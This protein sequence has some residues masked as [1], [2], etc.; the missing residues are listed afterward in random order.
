MIGTVRE[1]LLGLIAAAALLSAMSAVMPK[2]AAG[3]IARAGGGVVLLLVLLHPLAQ[4]S[5]K[6]IARQSQAYLQQIDA[7]IEEYRHLG[8]EEL[9][10]II[11]EKTSA[12]IS[13]KAAQ[14][15]IDCRVTVGTV[16]RDGVPF[17]DTVEL[18]A[19][20]NEELSR[21][22]ESELNIAKERQRWEV[23]G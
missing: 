22:I 13:E 4:F 20:K 16:L 8:E 21:W 3:T 15:G 9:A 23:E 19:R 18:T 14:M 1:W 5:P 17:P 7:Q 10:A 6:Q 2:T 12:Y 11:Q